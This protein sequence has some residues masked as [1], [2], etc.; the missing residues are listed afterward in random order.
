MAK[1]DLKVLEQIGNKAAR[2]PSEDLPLSVEYEVFGK[3][4]KQTPFGVLNGTRIRLK[5]SETT[6]WDENPRNFGPKGDYSDLE[7]AIRESG[8][9]TQAVDARIVNGK[10]QIIA[11][12]RRRYCCM[13]L[14]LPLTADLWDDINDDVACYIAETENSERKDIDLLSDYNYLFN[15][16][17]KL[18]SQD[19][20]MTVEQFAIRYKNKRRNMHNIFA[21]AKLP[22]WLKDCAKNRSSWSQRQALTLESYYRNALQT[23]TEESL[24]AVFQKQLTTPSQVLALLKEYTTGKEKSS[25]PTISSKSGISFNLSSNKSGVV[26]ISP[27]SPLSKEQLE[28]LEAFLKSL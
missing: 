10:V 4:I 21:I 20:S 6:L 18:K 8:G 16:F 12:S 15:R 7:D 23:N 19:D 27:D 9:N 28:K 26:K 24:K 11:G 25:I 17:N 3:V 1:L 14:D 2:Y 13:V 22:S 5:A